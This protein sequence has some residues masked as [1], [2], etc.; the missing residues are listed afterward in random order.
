MSGRPIGSQVEQS[1]ALGIRFS[2]MLV[3]HFYFLHCSFLLFHFLTC[4]CIFQFGVLSDN[5]FQPKF[6]DALASLDFKLSVSDICFYMGASVKAVF[7][8]GGVSIASC[9]KSS[10]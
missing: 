1:L 2:A 9:E 6:L 4:C 10:K 3:V 5:T 8:C 7:L